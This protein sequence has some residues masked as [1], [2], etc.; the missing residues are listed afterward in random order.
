MAARV[1][2]YF[3]YLD[4]GC[5]RDMMGWDHC[6]R[7]CNV[8]DENVVVNTANGSTVVSESGDLE[9]SP[10][11]HIKEGLLAKWLPFTLLSLSSRLREGWDFVA[12][13]SWGRLRNPR[14]DSYHFRVNDEGLFQLDDN[15][16]P[17]NAFWVEQERVSRSKLPAGG[18]GFPKLEKGLFYLYVLAMIITMLSG[19]GLGLASAHAVTSNPNSDIPSF[20]LESLG[21]L[22]PLLT[23]LKRVSDHRM[24]PKHDSKPKKPKRVKHPTITTHQHN[25]QCHFPYD[26]TCPWCIRARMTAKPGHRKS[27]DDLVTGS[28][29]G[30]VL[31][32]DY[33]GPYS[34]D[35]D[36]NI[37]GFVGVEVAHTQY[38]FVDLTTDKEASNTATSSLKR[39]RVELE[40]KSSDSKTHH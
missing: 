35:V 31:G 29:K 38:G 1:K 23:L 40:N 11:L 14:G 25:C 17:P 36:G 27:V 16:P 30:F 10:G 12:K 13:G 6:S 20:D 18:K 19:S 34:P 5:T 32:V 7:A 24:I 15:T 2:S 39:I 22:A 21:A 37:W 26:S 8:R 28:E 33:I 3:T 9:V 4:S